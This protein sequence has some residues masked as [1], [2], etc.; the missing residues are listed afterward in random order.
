LLLP[1]EL[2]WRCV[3]G[4]SDPPLG[5]Y[6]PAFGARIPTVTLLGSGGVGGD[7]VLTTVLQLDHGT[8]R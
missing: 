6:S 5:W 4:E 2:S 1:E 8:Q 3:R 7:V